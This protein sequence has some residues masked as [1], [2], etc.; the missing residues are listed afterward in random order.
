MK[1]EILLSH[2]KI[3]TL[4]SLRWIVAAFAGVL[5]CC[6]T[7]AADNQP[8][9]VHF[10]EP[11]QTSY[12][13]E[14]TT[15]G[16]TTARDEK[17]QAK[18]Q[19]SSR[20]VLKTEPGTDISEL[21]ANRGLVISRV[22]NSNLFILQARDSQTAIDAAEALAR[23]PGVSASHPVMRRPMRHMNTLAAAPNDPYFPLLWHLDNRGPDGTFA[24]PGQLPRELTSLSVWAMTD[25]NSTI[26][27]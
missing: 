7:L 17:S 3:K 19:I 25:F 11:H 12:L 18:V 10:R 2:A 9:R 22:I 16:W 13:L 15:A 20:I 21:L 14:Q 8:R 23:Q 27:N 24:L 5:F 6:G 1:F 4:S 26:P